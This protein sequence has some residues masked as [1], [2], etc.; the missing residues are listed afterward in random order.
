MGI[1]YPRNLRNPRLNLYLIHLFCFLQVSEILFL[2]LEI[3]LRMLTSRTLLGRFLA[4]MD[5]SAFA[6]LPGDFVFA[7]EHLFAFDVHHQSLVA[8]FV[9]L[10]GNDDATIHFGNL[11]ES[12]LLGR[13]GKGGIEF[14]SF[15][16]LTGG[17]F[18]Q[19]FQR[20][21]DDSCGIGSGDADHAT[22]QVF[23][24]AL[25][26]HTFLLR[27]FQEDGGYLFVSVL[28]GLFGEK[29]VAVACLRFAGKGGQ[30]VLLSHGSF[31][32]FAH[33]GNFFRVSD[34]I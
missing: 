34:R 8:L 15:F 3:V 7:A 22:L 12:L 9:G 1:I 4:T 33:N 26:V 29:G 31:N 19:V 28:Y 20:V 11:G 16:V 23:K 30:Q 17:G 21:S 32:T 5:V 27:R 6:A 10:F 24:H 2:Q 25:G 18:L 13:G 14:E